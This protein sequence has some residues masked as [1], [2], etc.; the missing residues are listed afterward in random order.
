ML[1]KR[2]QVETEKTRQQVDETL[3]ESLASYCTVIVLALFAFAFVCQNFEIPSGSMLQTILIGDHVLVDHITLS[4]KSKWT[5]F[6][7]YRE[8][9][10]GDIVVFIKPNES[11]LTLVKR[12]IG[13]PGDRIHLQDG[14]VFLNGKPQN[15]P[16][17]AKADFYFPYRDDFP[18]VPVPDG[19]GVTSLWAVELPSHVQGGD[20]VVPPGHYFVMGDNRPDSL[21]SRFWGFVPEENILGR[22]MFVYWSFVT[23]EDQVDKTSLGE[24][25][26]FYVHVVT[27][28]LSDTRWSR[29]LHVIR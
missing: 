18:N 8:V 10:R 23:P 28:F 1:G 13:V 5:P 15:E 21:D 22:P 24:R 27:H 16:L 29:T 20:L 3:L 2:G 12:V 6:V 25:A 19:I 4:A 26:G 17:A 9:R 7:H 14:V 11:T